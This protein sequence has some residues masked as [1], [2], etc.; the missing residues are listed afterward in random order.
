MVYSAFVPS[1]NTPNRRLIFDAN[2]SLTDIKIT[3]NLATAA[4]LG[5]AMI[6]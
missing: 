3:E 6:E 5:I 2:E 4:E 1:L